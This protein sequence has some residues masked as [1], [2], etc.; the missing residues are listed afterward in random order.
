M[1]KSDS[2]SN[3]PHYVKVKPNVVVG[4]QNCS[5]DL[6]GR[7]KMP[8]IRPGV[9]LAHAAT[10]VR[11]DRPLVLY[12]ALV[13][14]EHAPLAGIQTSVTRGPRRQHA[15]HHVDPAGHII[16]QM[17]RPADTHEIPRSRLRQ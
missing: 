1:S 2:L 12:V 15:I 14:D 4:R 17:F 6:S 10:A 7:E 13:L 3:L 8:K 9:S 5:S 11:I 16:G